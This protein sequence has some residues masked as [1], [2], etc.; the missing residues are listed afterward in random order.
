MYIHLG[1]IKHQQ[2]RKY[3]PNHYS[4]LG[5]ILKHKNGINLH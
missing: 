1:F 3:L 2:Q 5:S 4:E